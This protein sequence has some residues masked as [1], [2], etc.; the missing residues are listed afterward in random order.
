MDFN[1]NSEQLQFA[2]ALK[3]W[4]GRDYS[5]EARRGIIQSD[6]ERPTPPGPRWPNWA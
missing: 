4:I 1:F 2:D 5:F 6:A 3:R